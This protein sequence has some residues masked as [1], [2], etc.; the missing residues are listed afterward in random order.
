MFSA[1]E[2]FLRSGGRIMYLGGN[3]FYWVTTVDPE[4][5]YVIEVRRQA[6][7]RTWEAAP[8][9]LFHSTTGEL[10]GLWVQSAKELCRLRAPHRRETVRVRCPSGADRVRCAERCRP[11]DCE[12]GMSLDS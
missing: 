6:G 3:G 5:P 1:L 8:G 4:R 7:M 10:G 2:A 9:E 11:Q 12:L